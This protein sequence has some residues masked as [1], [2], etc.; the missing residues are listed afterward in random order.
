MLE[1]RFVAVL[2]LAL[3]NEAFLDGGVGPILPKEPP[4]IG[5]EVKKRN[6]TGDGLLNRR[7]RRPDSSD[8]RR[9]IFSQMLQN[10]ASHSFKTPLPPVVI[11]IS[12]AGS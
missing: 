8:W 4:A 2:R 10:I 11:E 3:L 1:L 7:G 9:C 12:D 5:K 6:V